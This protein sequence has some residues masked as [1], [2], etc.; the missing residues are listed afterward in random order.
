MES[1]ERA[2]IERLVGHDEELARLWAQHLEFEMRIEE[3]ESRPYLSDRE[4]V[5][6]AQLKKLKLAGKDRIAAILARR[7]PR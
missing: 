5:E 4:S 3:L 2:E 7:A 1:Y 6:R